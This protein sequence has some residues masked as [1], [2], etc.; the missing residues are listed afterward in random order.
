MAPFS[1][2]PRVAV[3]SQD[4]GSSM[5]HLGGWGHAC[6]VGTGSGAVLARGVIPGARRIARG[7]VAHSA[8][9]SRAQSGLDGGGRVIA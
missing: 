7:I 3:A 6:G 1:P 9:H 4:E 8:W 5:W 2:M